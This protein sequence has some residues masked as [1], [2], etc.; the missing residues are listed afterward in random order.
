MTASISALSRKGVN[1]VTGSGMEHP[2][3]ETTESNRIPVEDPGPGAE[4]EV[5]HRSRLGRSGEAILW[6]GRVHAIARN[7]FSEEY[8]P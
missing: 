2:R 3:P 4:R 7:P 5:D 8:D 1:N 6:S